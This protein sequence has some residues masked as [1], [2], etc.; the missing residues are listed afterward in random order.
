[1]ILETQRLL[2][3]PPSLRDAPVIRELAG[4]PDIAATTLTLPHPYPDGAAEA[5]IQAAAERWSS[6][7]SM[8]FTS[9]VKPI[10]S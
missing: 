3:R 10:S 9:S 2:L 1:M 7:E 4:H 5:F 6:G 8:T